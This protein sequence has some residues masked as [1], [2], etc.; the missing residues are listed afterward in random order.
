MRLDEPCRTAGPHSGLDVALAAAERHFV[1]GPGMQAQDRGRDGQG[2]HRVGEP[3]FRWQVSWVA[4]HQVG[5]GGP[6]HAAARAV[7]QGQR[8]RLCDNGGDG[9]ARGRAWCV[10]RQ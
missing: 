9:N 5:Y 3:V 4:A 10:R 6:A 7:G 1:V 2:R 8:A